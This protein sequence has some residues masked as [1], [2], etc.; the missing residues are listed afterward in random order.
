MPSWHVV[1][2][3][4]MGGRSSS[5]VEIGDGVLRFRGELSLADGGGFASVRTAGRTWN[6]VGRR[7][8][9]LTVRGDG[10]EYQVRLHDGSL[11]QGKRVT[12]AGRFVAPVDGW[13]Q[14]AVALDA[15][16]PVC[17]GRPVP[18]AALTWVGCSTWD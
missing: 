10:R 15:L 16:A 12:H 11:W 9:L 7:G 5:R 2:D 8:L 1:N 18:G 13:R 3:P 14:V 6:L 17:R 4:V